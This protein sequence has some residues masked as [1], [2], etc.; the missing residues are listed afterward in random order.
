MNKKEERRKD[1]GFLRQIKKIIP[2]SQ[3]YTE[4]MRKCIIDIINA[5]FLD[6]VKFV[7]MEDNDL[8]LKEYSPKPFKRQ[9]YNWWLKGLEEYWGYRGKTNTQVTRSKN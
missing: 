9:K 1:T 6:L 2:M 5:E 4:T 8:K 7:C 3:F